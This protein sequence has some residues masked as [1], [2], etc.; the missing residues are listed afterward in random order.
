[1]VRISDVPS[2][3][4]DGLP[5]LMRFERDNAALDDDAWAFA[6]S[7]SLGEEE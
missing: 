1:M 3:I 2:L 4:F 6:S 5:D 7:E